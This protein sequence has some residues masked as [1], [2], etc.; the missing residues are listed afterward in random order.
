M[1][2]T[3]QRIHREEGAAS[4]EYTLLVTL[5]AVAVIGAVS[6]LGSNIGTSLSDTAEALG[7]APSPTTTSPVTQEE[8]RGRDGVGDVQFEEVGGEV[9]I[10]EV[11]SADGWTAKTTK[12]NGSKAVIRF[13]NSETGERVIVRGW[14]NKKGRLKTSVK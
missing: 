2:D 12:D 13:T 8:R 1:A 6:F 3:R 5:I 14:I 11:D 10:A 7:S 9:R 4:V